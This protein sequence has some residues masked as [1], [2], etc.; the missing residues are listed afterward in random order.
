MCPLYGTIYV[1]IIWFLGMF[2]KI[3]CHFFI[4]ICIHCCHIILE[5]AIPILSLSLVKSFAVKAKQEINRL[6]IS[7]GLKASKL[8]NGPAVSFLE[9]RT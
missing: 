6:M 2:C 8:Q 5:W 7:V 9:D 1:I 4:L 3:W